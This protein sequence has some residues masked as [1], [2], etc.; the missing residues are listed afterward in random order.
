MNKQRI[1]SR[2]LLAIAL[3]ALGASGTAL[4]VDEVEQNSPIQN[5]QELTVGSGGSVTVNGVIAH[6]A[7]RVPDVDFY[8]FHGQEG[9]LITIDI[10]G[11]T[12]DLDTNLTLFDPGFKVRMRNQDATRDPGSATELDARIDNPPYRLDATG[13]WTVGVSSAPVFF[14]DGGTLT[15]T[16]TLSSGAYILIISG[17]TPLMQH[18]NIEIKPGSGEL[19]PLNP[20]AKGTIP[21]AL[22]SSSEFNA[23]DVNVTTLTFG[24]TGDE[25]SLRRCGKEGEDVNGDGRPDLVCHFE[26]EVA[27]FRRGDLAGVVKGKTNSGKPFTGS[28]DLKVVPEKRGD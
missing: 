25:A 10:D 15:S 20:K 7:P 14:R 16:A 2:T 27:N 6:P 26:N 11:T 19:A 21:V 23:L 17:V 4:A 12:N 1:F 8:K 28:G 13:I 24:A 9:D 22:L 5:A 3:A 18:I